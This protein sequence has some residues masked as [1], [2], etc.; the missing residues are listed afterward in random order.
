MSEGGNSII[1]SAV[2]REKKGGGVLFKIVS[3][4]VGNEKVTRKSKS[5]NLH[6]HTQ[7]ENRQGFL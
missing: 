5:K 7:R 2:V 1:S 6:I 3:L 4:L